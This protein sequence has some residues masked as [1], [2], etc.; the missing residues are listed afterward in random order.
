LCALLRQECWWRALATYTTKLAGTTAAAAAAAIT[1]PHLPKHPSK[2]CLPYHVNQ[3]YK[4]QLPSDLPLYVQTGGVQ[5]ALHVL[6]VAQLWEVWPW[7]LEQLQAAAAVASPAT[8]MSAASSSSNTADAGGVDMT[9]SSDGSSSSSSS[10]RQVVPAHWAPSMLRNPKLPPCAETWPI[11]LKATGIEWPLLPPHGAGSVQPGA[12]EL[13][14]VELQ[15]LQLAVSALSHGG[16]S[17][18][19]G[20]AALLLALLLQRADPG[21]RAPFLAGPGGTALLAAVQYWGYSSLNPAYSDD[22]VTLYVPAD[23]SR[24]RGVPQ[25][26]AALQG[27]G[28]ALSAAWEALDPGTSLGLQLALCYLVPVEGW[29]L[30]VPA[31]WGAAPKWQRVAITHQ[32]YGALTRKQAHMPGQFSGSSA[33]PPI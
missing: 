32:C 25:L 8:P 26:L 15:Q 11:V 14:P 27:K 6:L 1:P 19:A 23:R 17:E 18:V 22:E 29:E 28:A 24:L 16:D 10:S 5:I 20:S 9:C 13:P 4:Y 7:Q 12:K 30:E 21:L 2:F 3:A 33:V 31:A